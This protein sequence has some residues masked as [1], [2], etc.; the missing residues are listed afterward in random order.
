[1]QHISDGVS[2]RY[3]TQG[4]THSFLMLA[5]CGV[6]NAH[7]EKNLA[8]IADFVEFAKSIVELIVVITSQSGYPSLDFL[9]NEI[10]LAHTSLV[11]SWRY[12]A[13][14]SRPTC[15]SDI[16]PIYAQGHK[17]GCGVAG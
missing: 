7:V 16:V 15:L 10:T 2:R 9:C 5:Q 14:L 3:L 8:R 11:P 4:T 6:D 13:L 1:M 17:D 12:M